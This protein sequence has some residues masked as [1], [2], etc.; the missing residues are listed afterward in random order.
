MSNILVDLHRT[1][2]NSYNGLYHFCY[3][4]GKHLALEAPDDMHLHFY[5]PRSQR[6]VFGDEVKYVTQ[7]GLHKYFHQLTSRF[8]IWHVATTLSWYRPYGSKT[9]NIYTI[10]DLNFLHEEEYSPAIRKRY[11]SLIQQ[12]IDRA[13]YLTFISEFSLR[14]TQELLKPGNKP[15]SIIHN[16]CNIPTE[17]MSVPAEVPSKPFLFSIGQFHSRK[18][19]HVLPALLT[20]NDYELIIAG[21]NN[22]NYTNKVIAEA[23]NLGVADRLKLVGAVS[24]EEKSWYYKNCLAFVFPSIG[25]GFGLPVLEAMYFGKPVFLSRFTSL[26]EIGGDVAYYF[27]NFDPAC[28]KEVFEKGMHHYECNQPL[29][30]IKERAKSFSWEKAVSEYLEVY[31]QFLENKK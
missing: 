7:Y 4:L 9:K 10:H 2:G 21:M 11:L 22:F 18:N 3:Q 1:G 19:F 31:R 23:K 26:P 6:L 29:K 5:V 16:G 24:E 20:G 17:V 15:F 12:R 30:K 25:E 28:M 14:Q 13:D 8:D 27:D